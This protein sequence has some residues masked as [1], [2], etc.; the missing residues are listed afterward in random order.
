MSVVRGFPPTAFEVIGGG[1][2]FLPADVGATMGFFN[3]VCVCVCVCVC[4]YFDKRTD[5]Y[6]TTRINVF[7][8]F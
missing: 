1:F 4:V 8:V 2:T 5:N 3:S 7:W 6:V